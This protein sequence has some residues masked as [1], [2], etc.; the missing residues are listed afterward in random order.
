MAGRRLYVIAWNKN[1]L[2]QINRVTERIQCMGCRCGMIGKG[3]S[4]AG[5]QPIYA[6]AFKLFDFFEG[7]GFRQ[8]AL[9]P[10]AAEAGNGHIDISS[11]FCLLGF[12][13]P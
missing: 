12:V 4:L 6:A 2:I 10:D 1:K 9:M 13:L 5:E 8:A 11:D 7:F 3:F